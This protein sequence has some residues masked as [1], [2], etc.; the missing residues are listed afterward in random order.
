MK[1]IIFVLLFLISTSVSK[2]SEFD[3]QAKTA[4]LQDF[5]SGEILYEKK[6]TWLYIQPP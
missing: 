3:I 1:K 4:I 5:L 2:S 6:P